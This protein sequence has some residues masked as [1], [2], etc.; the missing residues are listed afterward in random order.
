MYTRVA[1]QWLAQKSDLEP[2]Q[3][4]FLLEALDFYR[5]LSREQESSP[6]PAIRREAARAF[7]RVADLEQRLGR[8]REAESAFRMPW[9]SWM[10]WRPTIPTRT[11]GR[12]RR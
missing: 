7:G 3:R 8:L 4:T 5:R 9:R 12:R 2:L 6:D 11:T 1:E 10:P